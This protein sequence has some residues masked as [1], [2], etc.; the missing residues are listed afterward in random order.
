MIRVFFSRLLG[1][2]FRRHRD[3][4]VAEEIQLHLE[5][6]TDDYM[7]RG[8]TLE[9]AQAAARRAF[10]GIAQTKEAYRDQS[11]L[12]FVDEFV[13]DVRFALRLLRRDRTYSL[14]AILVLALGIGVNNMLF[15]I[16]NAHTLR[17]LPI[18]NVERVVYVSTFDD[19]TPDRGLSYPDFED[20]RSAAQHVSLAA[21]VN[22]PMVVAEDNRL[23]E[24]LDG[25]FISQNVFD[26]LRAQPVLGRGFSP[27]EGQPGAETVAIIGAGVWTSRYGADRSVLGRSIRVD[28][29]TAVI[30]GVMC[31]AS[32]FPSSA[33]VWLPL[34]QMPGLTAQPRDARTL[35]VF[36][37]IA[38]GV[39]SAE[40]R[41]E[42]ESI[43]ERLSR[44]HS[45]TNK[46]VR[47]RVVPINERF[48]GRLTD[49][50]WLA[51]MTVGCLI[52]LISCANVA[53]LIL[54]NSARRA[55]EIAIR[56]SL[57]ASRRRVLRQL[58]I[59]GTVLAAI[60]GAL[61]MV[62]AMAGVRLFRT[63]IPPNVLPYWLDYALDLRVF[64]ALVAVSLATVFVFGFPTALHSSKT[65]VI[66]V[67]K[68]GG[69]SPPGVRGTQR[70][71]TAFLAVEFGLAVILLVQLTMTMRSTL[72]EVRSDAIIDSREVLTFAVT[73][74]TAT[75]RT[76]DQRTEFY[77]RLEERL[78]A[79]AA[80]SVVSVASALPLQGAPQ[81]PIDI[82]GRTAP[83]G[84]RRAVRTVMI[85]PRY[86]QALGLTLARGR[87]FTEDDGAAGHAHAI[88]NERMVSEFFGGEDPV[89]Q[90]I[91]FAPSG[92]A[93]GRDWLTIVGVAPDVRQRPTLEPDAIV[94]T[95]YRSVSPATASL[96]IRSPNDAS[97]LASWVRGEVSAVDSQL[98]LY[99]MRTMAQALRDSQWNGRLSSTLFRVLTLIAIGLSAV[100]L[101]AVTSY[102]VNQRTHELG[103]RM[104]LGAR[105]HHVVSVLGWRVLKQ[106]SFGFFTG[107]VGTLLWQ[108]MFFTGGGGPSA[109]D[110]LSLVIVAAML[111]AIA[112][113]ACAVPIRRA[114]RLDPVQA[115]RK[116]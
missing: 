81:Q 67:L 90:R 2:V 5:R 16:V 107:L 25:A 60:G 94:Y 49:P 69:T 28:G 17:G 59:E 103:L 91:A 3:E 80:V 96:L 27:N 53:N 26:L 68:D 74:P 100:G 85:A 82:Q 72:P 12:P 29:R 43:V 57:G 22:A 4:I 10:G 89:G 56:S 92:A 61:G 48:L 78:R 93:G 37:R 51:F 76:L 77:R 55:R 18:D 34:A 73:L 106:L 44:D 70:W 31:A 11:G 58:V 32:G 8:M 54:A 71:S 52:A 20:L 1:L 38:D 83:D 24:R 64:L 66:A 104:T 35:S 88:V 109:A 111:T 108:W 95:P 65:D 50:A 30:V 45:D 7:K 33:E 113:I 15:T 14:T 84:Q 86:F 87:D 75:Y 79:N 13:Q 112:A 39:T 63:A 19:R 23:A 9:E 105:T 21:F 6:L 116:M 110:P 115:L 36:G 42:I 62:L 46:N 40:A 101:Y 98:P 102:G 97:D 41:A 114:T 99:R 47:A